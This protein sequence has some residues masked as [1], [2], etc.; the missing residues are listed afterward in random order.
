MRLALSLICVFLMCGCP[1][2]PGER[3]LTEAVADLQQRALQD[4]TAWRLLESLTGE[5]GPR[6]A[7]SAADARAVAWAVE[8]MNDLGFDRVWLE[9]VDFPLWVRDSESGRVLSPEGFELDLTA[10]GGT[11]GTGGALR[12]EVVHFESLQTLEAAEPGSLDG[13]IAF[14][15][16]AMRR[17]QGAA[18]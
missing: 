7:G 14:I 9:P 11:P 10:L 2:A 13:K 4:E 17:D 5:V 8:Q 3:S 16:A 6:M 18:G 15:S 1:Q 12:G